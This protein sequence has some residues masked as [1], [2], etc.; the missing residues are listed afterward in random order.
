MKT[1]EEIVKDLKELISV[2]ISNLKLINE[3]I[4]TK[5]IK[6]HLIRLELVSNRIKFG[7]WEYKDYG[8]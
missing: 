6:D 2:E 8:T 5:S 3:E 1:K 7:I 4:D